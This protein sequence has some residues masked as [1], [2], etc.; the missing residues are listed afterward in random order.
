MDPFER[1]EAKLNALAIPFQL[2][3]HEP[4]YTTAAADQYIEGIPGVR[5]KTM[6]LTNRRK[7]NFYLVIMDDKKRLDMDKF[8]TLVGEKKIRMASE[9]SLYEKMQLTAGTV[10]PFGLLNNADHDIDVYI[11]QDIVDEARMS[12][13]PNTND[14][15]LFV[16]TSDLF[17]FLEDL[18]YPA[19][20][21]KLSCAPFNA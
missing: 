3:E 14:K 16:R 10:S 12:F 7:S 5:T 20:I 9:E 4:A 11:D 19:H 13:H 8:K 6:F 17:K 21:V 1:V 2:V 15:T 18:A